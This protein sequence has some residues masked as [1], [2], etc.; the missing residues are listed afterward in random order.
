MATKCLRT[1]REHANDRYGTTHAPIWVLNFDLETKECFPRYNDALEERGAVGLSYSSTVPYGLGHRAIRVSQRPAGCSNLLVDQPMIRAATLLDLLQGEKEF[2]APVDDYVRWV[3]G[4][5]TDP[6][7]GLLNWGIHTSYDVFHENLHQSD[8]AQHEVQCILPLWPVFDRVDAKRT[9]AYLSKFWYRHTDPK[10]CIVDRHATRGR[11]L[12]FSM[13]AGEVVLVCAYLH[14]KDPDGPWLDR[15]LQVAHSHYDTRNPK[16]NLFV[17]TARGGTGKR[18][19]NTYSDTSVT[20]LWASRVPPWP[21]RIT[22][23]EELTEMARTILR[24]WAKYGWDEKSHKPWAS[25]RPDGTPHDKGRDYSGVKYSKF[26]PSGHWDF[27]KDYVYGFEYPFATLM[28]YAAAA[29]WLDDPI[30]E[31]HAKRLAECYRKLLPAN[32]DVGTFAAN[33]GQLISFYLAMERLTGDASYRETAKQVADEAVAHLWTGDCF[34]GFAGRTHYS[35]VE[36]AGYLVQALVELGRRSETVSR[37]P[38]TARL[39]H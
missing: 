30:L 18:F 10:T 26:D 13:A 15:A 32:G 11:G 38:K 12:D 22:G 1:I 33:Y 3:F 16:T 35:A 25:L 20:G 23:N 6:E 31:N 19:D 17:N 7:T 14:T 9:G 37:N 2:T 4:N 21:G 39:S 24:A 8:G 36:G 34:R 28:T 29:D 5:L 27:W